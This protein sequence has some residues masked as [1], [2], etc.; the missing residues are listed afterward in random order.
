APVPRR[1]PLGP[2]RGR[3]AV[4]AAEG[5]LAPAATVRRR[6]L[7]HRL[8]RGALYALAVGLG[9]VFLIPYLWGLG[10][11]LKTPLETT[12]IP[13]TWVPRVPQ[14]QN[15]VFVTQV[16]PFLTFARNSVFLTLVNI[17]G[18]V[19]VGAAVAYGFARF[20]FRGRNVL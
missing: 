18:E 12:A 20:R 13:P 16:T 10:T 6:P 17:V 4:S 19:V 3:P 8:G 1:D 14:W 15:Y 9:A 5:A 11:S 7:G 2:L